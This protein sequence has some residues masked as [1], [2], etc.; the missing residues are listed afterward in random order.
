M[1][2]YLSASLGPS[3]HKLTYVGIEPSSYGSS[4][5]LKESQLF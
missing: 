2:D 4:V 3:L 1:Q 5:L